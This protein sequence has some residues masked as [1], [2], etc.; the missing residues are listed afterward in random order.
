MSSADPEFVV[1]GGRIRRIDELDGDE[2]RPAAAR[3]HQMDEVDAATTGIPTVEPTV[4][5]LQDHLGQVV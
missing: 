5:R 3:R 2:E 1:A 4:V